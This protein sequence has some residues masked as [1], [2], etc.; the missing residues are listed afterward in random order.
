MDLQN[1]A[2]WILAFYV[3]LSFPV[4]NGDSCI[5]LGFS[6]N[7]LCSSCQ[8]LKQFDLGVLEDDCK[9]CCHSEGVA[10][11]EKVWTPPNLN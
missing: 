1:K 8:E 11:E 6:S 3:L 5:D 10:S 9:M 7:L 4:S 2:R